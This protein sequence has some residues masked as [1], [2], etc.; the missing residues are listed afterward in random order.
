[1]TD[2]PSLRRSFRLV[3][4]P[5]QIPSVEA[6]LS[7]QGF[8]FEPEPFS[9]LARR[10]L[11]E[12]FP[13]GRSLA[14]CPTP[15]RFDIVRADPLVLID[16]CHNPQSCETFI[17]SIGEIAP[18]RASRP[19]LLIATL[20]DKDSQGIV[21]ALAPEFPRIIVAR[22][23]SPRALAASELARAVAEELEREGRPAEDLVG[24]F[25]SVAEA[26]AFATE[27]ALPVVAAG[28]ITLAG[29]VAGLLRG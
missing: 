5:G 19:T 10:L 7:A 3:C 25:C 20:T 18:E 24:T 13:L 6:L 12:P 8:V 26:L 22:T 29:E 16:A 23:A 15:G 2:T 28:T 17:S 1:M 21:R 9:P 11:Q 4:N 14:A 27:R